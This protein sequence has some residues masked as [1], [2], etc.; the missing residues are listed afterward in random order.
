MENNKTK[1]Q[2]LKET[3]QLRAKI[4]G[5]EKTEVEHK[6]AEEALRKNE[7]KFRLLAE[8]SIDCIWKL[9]T[10]LRFIYLSPSVEK[11]MGFKPEQWEGTKLSSHF[12]KREFLKVGALAAKAIINYKTFTS[13]TFETKM[14]NSKNEEVDIEISANVLLNNQGKLI[15]LQ[16]T[17]KDITERKQAEEVLQESEGRLRIK[18]DYI[19]STDKEVKNISL[20]DLIDLKN[21]QQIQDAFAIAN[22]VASIISDVDGKPITKASNFCG[23]CE[24]I[25][26]TKK[27]NRNCNKSDK[28]LGE[29]AKALLKPTFEKCLSCGFVDASAPIIIGGKHIANWLIGQSNVMGVG[30]ERIEAYAK[31]IGADTKKMLD[32]F[33]TMPQITLEKFEKVLDLLWHFAKEL[34]TLGYNNLKLI[35]NITEIKQAE[36]ELQK[37]EEQLRQIIDTVP[38]MIFAKD[39]DG[40]FI[41]ANKTVADGCGTTHENMIGKTHP[42][43]LGATPE[44]FEAYQNDDREIIDSGELKFIPE[45]DYTHPEGHK[46]IMETTKIPF[47][48]A[49]VPAVLGTSVDITERKQAEEALELSNENF[50]QVVSNITTVVWKADIGENGAFENTYSSPVLDE[51]LALPAGTMKNDWDKYFRYIK[52]EYLELVNNAFRVAIESPGKQI[53]CEYEVLKDNGQTAWFHSKGRCFEKNGKLNV[54]GSTIDI[55]ERKQ[56]EEALQESEEKYRNLTENMF[57]IVY[58]MDTN[59]ILTYI[60]PQTKQYGIDPEK[61]ISKNLLEIV[62]PED[63]EK[64][65]M[66]FQRTLETGKEFPST[67][68]VLNAKGDIHWFEDIGRIQRNKNGNITGL[69]GVLRDITDRKQTEKNLIQKNEQFEMV[70]Q[71]ANLGWWDWDIPS[72]HENYNEILTKNLGYKLGEIEPDIKWWKDK[73]HPDDMKQVSKDLQEHFDGETE[74]YINKHRLKTRTGKWKWFSDHG[75]VVERDKTGKPI[76][77]VG[78]LRNIDKQVQADKALR[79]SEEKYRM[80]VEQSGQ[81]MYDY[82]I[83][84]GKINW[85]GDILVITGYTV[86]EFQEVDILNWEGLIHADDRKFAK[87]L[88]AQAIKNCSNY[89]V[90]YRFKQKG[91]KYIYV[92][93]SGIFLV[94]ANGKVEK[95]LG[96]MKDITEQKKVEAEIQKHHKHLEELVKERTKELEDKNNELDK[97]MKVFVGRELAIRDLQNRI[98]ALEGN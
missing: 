21:L 8:N 44:Q 95:M 71:G 30:K 77:M 75:K 84:T 93:D 88:L 11:M 72:G 43:L 68:R 70:I 59:G 20:A 37:K 87:E 94:D 41:M 17:T 69:A 64:L 39:R 52:P 61:L 49:G 27:G 6:Q 35:K 89:K 76:R 33:E 13:V 48:S 38:H 81:M 7:E 65:G 63:R 57:D 79:E 91:G 12:T 4:A 73:I 2:L 1:E 22:N 80:L 14:L 32:A 24:I 66:E 47:T 62:H 46:V 51:L 78:T 28:I 55:T 16:G 18:L 9:D 83:S 29:K 36:E 26:S 10:K 19:L 3:V 92:E 97:A 60:S 40:R 5:L 67:F 31:E 58:L 96:L 54:F 53:D 98:K 23:V 34:S 42:E 74:Y 86:K 56:A 82:H 50:Q 85:S 45:E 90:E 15:G 25:R